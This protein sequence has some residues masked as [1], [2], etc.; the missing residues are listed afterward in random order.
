MT[1]KVYVE[2]GGDGRDLR[3]RC[4]KGFSAFFEKAGLAG[5]MPRVVACGSRESAFDRF[6][7]AF[8]AR[9]A[10]EFVALLV[11]S[12]APVADGTWGP[13]RIWQDATAGT[14]PAG[15]RTNTLT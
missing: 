11:D 13:G 3:T 14:S 12:E 5:R 10:G 2:G 15:Q 8:A 9:K 6:R 7:T 1:V 4:R